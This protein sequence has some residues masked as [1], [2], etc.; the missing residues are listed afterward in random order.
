ML[1]IFRVNREEA[2]YVQG[3]DLRGIVASIFEKMGV[4]A[5]DARLAADV[6]VV[7]DLR[8]VDTHGVSNM[9]RSY[10]DGYKSGQINPR[11]NWK[12]I[13]ESPS[14]ANIDSDRGLGIIVTPKAMEIAIRKAKA[15]G[16]GM[17]TI[18]NA[19]HLGMASYHA[20]MA[21]EHDMIG[22]CMTSCPPSVVP[23]FG[24][25]PRLGTNPIAVAAPAKDEPP[26]VFDAATS[27]VAGNKIGIAR[28]LGVKLEAGWLAGE[29]GTPI[30][31]EVDPPDQNYVLLPL[32]STRELGSHKGYGFS[33][34]VD[35][36][37]GILTG[38][39][40]GA[41]PGRPNF[42]HYVAAYSIDAFTD[43]E[44]FKEMMDEWMRMMKSTKPAPGQE[45]VMVAGQPEAEVAA[46][47]EVEGI[48]LHPEVVQWLKDTC[49][50]LSVPCR[51]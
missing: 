42:G 16:V 20:M 18:G 13:R 45:R 33:C 9:L 46:V 17:V 29:D 50:E 8:G 26:F 27:T 51:L 7:A 22:I 4:G 28:R 24:A 43:V 30:M 10:M 15:V 12:V 14:T 37:G 48:P 49:A 47:R 41:V 40:Y 1:E 39:G 38:V 34:I 2:E 35:I 19:R 23:T 36:L 11:P 5:A 6:L 31:E 32:G 21:L 44:R 3:D 25:E